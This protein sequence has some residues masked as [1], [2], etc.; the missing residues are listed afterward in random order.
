[1]VLSYFDILLLIELYDS[2]TSMIV[3]VEYLTCE[4]SG[5]HNI[6]PPLVLSFVLAGR[7][8]LEQPW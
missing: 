3:L 7:A 5:L 6:A 2:T 8:F 1:M 4:M